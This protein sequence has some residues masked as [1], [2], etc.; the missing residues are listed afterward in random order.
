M[1]V[2]LLTRRPDAYPWLADYPNI[3]IA[4]GDVADADSLRAAITGCDQVIHAAG[5]FRFWGREA[6]FD[7]TNVGGAE[8]VA[9]AAVDAGVSR[10]IHV[11]SAAVVGTPPRGREIDETYPANPIDPY[12]RSKWRA[13]QI[14]QAARVDHGL[15]VVILRPGAYYGAL[16][17]YAFNRLFFRD[18]MRGIAMQ[19]DGG[20]YITFPTYVPDVAQCVILAL[21]RGRT[22]EA[23]NICGE[24]LTH[25]EVFDIVYAEAH[26][27][28]PRLALPGWLGVATARALTAISA[29]T[30]REPF[31]PLHMR[32]YVYNDWRVSNAKARAELGF[33]PT[34]FREGAYRTIVWYRAGRPATIPEVEC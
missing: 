9:R 31:Y 20:S 18:P 30:G 34:P 12:Q 1:P 6:D 2:R 14:M 17:E 16:G 25:R 11:S 7:R 22:G 33:V 23:Y 13:E 10:L 24:T 29:I 8:N 3:E 27:R 15:N 28:F 19:M 32:S 4:R 21:E 26:L 5:L